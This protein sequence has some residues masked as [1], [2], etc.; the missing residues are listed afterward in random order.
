M[1]LCWSINSFEMYNIVEFSLSI[2]FIEMYNYS[3]IFF[4]VTF[5]ATHTSAWSSVKISHL[6]EVMETG[7]A[8]RY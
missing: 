5:S 8:G 7:T 4:V 1:E 3:G 2:N 6:L